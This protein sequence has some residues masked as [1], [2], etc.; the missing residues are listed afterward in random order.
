MKLSA[1]SAVFLAGLWLAAGMA[2]AQEP[3]PAGASNSVGPASAMPP[4]GPPAP[5]YGPNITLAQAKAVMAAAVAEATKR[6][7]R[8]AVFAIVQPNGTLVLFE[9]MDE[10]TYISNDFAL[11]KA[12]TAALTRH[13]SG[14]GPG[15][16]APPVPG[17]ISLPGGLPIIIDGHTVGAL[18]VS[19]VEGGDVA[20]A[21]AALAAV[22]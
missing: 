16:G 9:R 3:P 18:G 17:L 6:H 10:A 5:F 1:R 21:E 15:G 20:V 22:H 2:A 13:A 14:S 8:S 4:P 11:A 19:G 12:R 7:A